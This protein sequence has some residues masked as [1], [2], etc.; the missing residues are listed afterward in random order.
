MKEE[1]KIGISNY[2]KKFNK[3]SREE[4]IDLEVKRV[5]KYKSK[6]NAELFKKKLTKQ[7]LC[8]YFCNIDIRD[9]QS[10]IKNN[11]IYPRKR[12][13]HGYSGM[14]FE[15]EHLDADK[16]N[17][18]SNNIVLACYYCNNDKSNTIEPEIFKDFF[19][20]RKGEAFK[21]LIQ[22]KNIKSENL[23]WHHL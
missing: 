1:L 11:I 22:E 16:A 19:G 10:L 6:K 4:Y 7:E 17:D 20:K 23:Y 9:I 3:Y 5:D 18:N 21:C 14:H 15:I 13:N 12:G 8:C 2:L